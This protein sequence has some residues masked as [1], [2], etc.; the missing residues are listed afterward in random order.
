MTAPTRVLVAMP[1][2]DGKPEWPTAQAWSMIERNPGIVPGFELLP[3]KM[4]SW[5]AASS[6]NKMLYYAKR[7]GCKRVLFLDQ[8]QVFGAQHLARILSHNLP[9]VGGLYPAKEMVAKW[10][11]DFDPK[12]AD[13]NGLSPA[14]HIG[15]GFLCVSME[16]IEA[17][18]KAHPEYRY[19]CQDPGELDGK[20]IYMLFSE[21]VV[22]DHWDGP[23]KPA[24]Q[25]H[26][27]EDYY[28]CWLA[29]KAGIPVYADTKCLVGHIGTVDYLEMHAALQRAARGAATP[30]A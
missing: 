5:S 14:K 1:L 28:F 24:W 3:I 17:L 8:D 19:T 22:R 20:E 30:K 18:E 15:A 4:K 23:D 27:G 6:R 21:Q 26:L 2:Y 29:T 16:A 9:I 25:R 13:E 12:V 10:V 11:C 7:E